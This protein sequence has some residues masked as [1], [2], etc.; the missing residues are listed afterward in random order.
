MWCT[1]K[2][3]CPVCEERDMLHG[4]RTGGINCPPVSTKKIEPKKNVPVDRM[5]R[6]KGRMEV[7]EESYGQN[8]ATEH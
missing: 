6:A 3:N 4:H 7:T 2:V 5:E 1:S 8:L